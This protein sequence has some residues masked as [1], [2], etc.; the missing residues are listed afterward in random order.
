[1]CPSF[2]WQLAGNMVSAAVETRGIAISIGRLHWLIN[3]SLNT[4]CSR[5]RRLLQFQEA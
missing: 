3:F 4:G 1:M 2:T 5:A